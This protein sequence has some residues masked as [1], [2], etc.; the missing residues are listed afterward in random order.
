LGHGAL[1]V[2]HVEERQELRQVR[3]RPQEVFWA[4]IRRSLICPMLAFND[5]SIAVITNECYC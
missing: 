4:K 1:A 5:G 3:M 2:E